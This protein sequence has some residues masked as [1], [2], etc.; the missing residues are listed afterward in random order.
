MRRQMLNKLI[1]RA[2]KADTAVCIV[3]YLL[4]YVSKNFWWLFIASLAIMYLLG[5]AW[6]CSMLDSL[7]NGDKM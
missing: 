2:L 5:I 6:L 4:Q 3:A 1:T 7:V